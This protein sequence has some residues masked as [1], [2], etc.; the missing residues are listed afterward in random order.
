MSLDVSEGRA[1]GADRGQR[2]GQNHHPV[3]DRRRAAALQG[4][5]TFE[6]ESILGKSPEEITRKGIALVP[7]GREI[8]PSLTVEE[9]LRL[10][11]FV[12]RETAPS[13]S[14]TWTEMFDLFPI[15]GSASSSRG[16]PSP[17]ASSSSWRSPGR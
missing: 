5:I 11:A 2:R 12:R 3:H 9:N 4:T 1:G 14:A 16:G 15:L 7:E 8:F 13:S 6:G 10:G 17:A